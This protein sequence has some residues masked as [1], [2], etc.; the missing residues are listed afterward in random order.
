MKKVNNHQIATVQPQGVT[1]P[2]LKFLQILTWCCFI[3]VLLTKKSVHLNFKWFRLLQK[4]LQH[5][6]HHFPRASFTFQTFL[7]M[8][9]KVCFNPF[10]ARVP[11]PDPLKT[12]EN[13]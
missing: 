9:L 4:E 10:L 5:K 13:R 12:P 1:Y 6:S 11:V 8:S 2:L 7:R 3:K